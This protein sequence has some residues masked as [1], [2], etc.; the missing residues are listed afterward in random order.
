MNTVLQLFPTV[1]CAKEQKVSRRSP[2]TSGPEY[3]IHVS[4][5]SNVFLSEPV[6]TSSLLDCT[7]NVGCSSS[8][9]YNQISIRYVLEL[10][11]ALSYLKI[12]YRMRYE[13]IETKLDISSITVVATLYHIS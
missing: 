11:Y 7:T 2:E 4:L 3:C 5:I 6:S 13:S 1:S 8:F 9:K 10:F 12:F